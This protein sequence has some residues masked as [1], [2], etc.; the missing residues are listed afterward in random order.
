VAPLIELYEEVNKALRQEK[1][2][3]MAARPAQFTLK[4]VKR[5]GAGGRPEYMEAK[6]IGELVQLKLNFGASDGDS[7]PSEVKRG[8]PTSRSGCLKK[9]DIVSIKMVK[10]SSVPYAEFTM[11]QPGDVVNL[12]RNFLEGADRESFVAIYL[13][14][15]NEPNA[16][17]VVS[18][19]ALDRCHVHP[20]EVFKAA[21]LANSSCIILA[22]N[23]PSGN[24]SPSREDIE[25]TSRLKKAGEILGVEVLDHVIV[26]DNG[27]FVS[28][29]TKGLI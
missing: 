10:E 1:S 28:F 7:S 12:L 21:I 6:S 5:G 25:M 23:H 18:I 4:E 29:K 26:G 9:L 16:I 3:T 13:N 8:T 2:R 14:A 17:H 27:R 22:H 11:T 20:R 24:P 15:K 19:G